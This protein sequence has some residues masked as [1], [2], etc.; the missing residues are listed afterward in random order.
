MP[1]TQASKDALARD[2]NLCQW[3]LYREHRIRSVFYYVEGYHPMMGGGHHVIK[4]RNVDTAENVISLCPRHHSMAESHKIT[5]RETVELLSE[6]TGVDL[7][8]KYRE[9][10]NW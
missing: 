4:P 9:F 3:C 6:I 10:C 5:K 2:S 7:H 1:Q 8:T